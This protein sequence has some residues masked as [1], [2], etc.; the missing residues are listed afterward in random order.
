MDFSEIA[1][2]YER[3]SIVQ[4]GAAEVLLGLLA[5]GEAEDVLDLGCG[6]G[7]LTL[8]IASLTNGRVLGLD[9]SPAMIAEARR[10]DT[11]PGVSFEIR[12]AEDIDAEQR[13]DV[14]FSNSA[15]Q[16]FRDPPR[17][18]SH[19]RQA[20][21]PGG[22][23]GMQ[24]PASREYCPNFLRAMEEVAHHRATRD[25]FARFQSP[26]FFRETAEEYASLFTQAGFQVGFAALNTTSSEHIPE[27]ALKIFDSGA[28]AGYLN[29]N[30]Y[31]GHLED[32][33]A[34]RVRAVVLDSF[35]KQAAADGRVIL[36]FRRIYVVAFRRV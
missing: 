12:F 1:P 7:H 18:L 23:M 14:I 28:A 22:R 27:E 35:R 9:P 6:T 20:L 16:W 26:W 25:T 4:K 2:R 19:C 32:G 8:R 30:C 15:F 36:A 29:P 21:R 5:I 10:L 33:Y 13:F 24:A 11:R 3:D 34:E 31:G 17:V